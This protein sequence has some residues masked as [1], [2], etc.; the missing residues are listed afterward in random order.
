M[1]T[2]TS[3]STF[4]E[5]RS[6]CFENALLTFVRSWFVSLGA[7]AAA[8]FLY[9]AALLYVATGTISLEALREVGAATPLGLA[10]S[11]P[12]LYLGDTVADVLTVVRARQQL[13][14]QPLP[15][16]QRPHPRG[17]ASR[18]RRRP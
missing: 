18:D 3:K 17:Q 6:R 5:A 2:R 10:S 8:F 1:P 15:L 7:F 16:R 9:G 13:P 14:E 11:P 4:C 12:V